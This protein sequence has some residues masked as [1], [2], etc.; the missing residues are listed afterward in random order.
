MAHCATIVSLSAPLLK[1]ANF[2]PAMWRFESPANRQRPVR[3]LYAQPPSPVCAWPFPAVREPP[4]FRRGLRPSPEPFQAWVSARH[5][6]ISVWRAGDRS[7][8]C[9]IPIQRLA[10]ANSPPAARQLFGAQET[11]NL[12]ARLQLDFAHGPRR[13]GRAGNGRPSRGRD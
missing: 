3:I 13:H 12:A 9:D 2:D 5:F 10:S 1:A 4:T 11:P 6:L 7:D 8:K